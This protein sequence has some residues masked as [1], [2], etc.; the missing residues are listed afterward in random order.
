MITRYHSFE[1]MYNHAKHAIDIYVGTWE[2]INCARAG[3]DVPED[4]CIWMKELLDILKQHKYATVKMKDGHA[5]DVSKIANTYEYASFFDVYNHIDSF[6]I[7][8]KPV[9]IEELHNKLRYN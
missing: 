7:D 3:M 8:T 4:Q 5:V 9:I 1:E 6:D 2:N